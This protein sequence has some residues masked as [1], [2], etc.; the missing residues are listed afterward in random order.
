MKKIILLVLFL[1][2]F[3]LSSFASVNHILDEDG[4]N[5]CFEDGS[6]WVMEDSTD[7]DTG[8]G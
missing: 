2:L 5:L 3:P 6:N 8:G 7:L 1:L 4:N